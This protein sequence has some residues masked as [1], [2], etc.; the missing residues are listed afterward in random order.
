MHAIVEQSKRLLEKVLL[1]GCPI[2]V[3][4]KLLKGKKD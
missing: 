3:I 4:L 2:L 1:N